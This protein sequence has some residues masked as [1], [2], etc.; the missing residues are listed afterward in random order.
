MELAS[1]K[2]GFWASLVTL[3]SPPLMMVLEAEQLNLQM[4]VL[5]LADAVP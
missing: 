1:I 5:P 4:T 3:K 2:F